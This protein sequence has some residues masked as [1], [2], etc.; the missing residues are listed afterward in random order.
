G[1][2]FARNSDVADGVFHGVSLGWRRHDEGKNGRETQGNCGVSKCLL[3]NSLIADA[4][5][6]SRPGEVNPPARNRGRGLGWI[7][8]VIDSESADP[9]AGFQKVALTGAGKV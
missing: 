6:Q 1:L 3:F 5:E 7:V 9:V 4:M 8:E 2:F